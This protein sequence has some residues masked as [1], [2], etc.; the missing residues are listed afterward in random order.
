MNGEK[1]VRLCT[2]TLTVELYDGRQMPVEMNLLIATAGADP[3]EVVLVHSEAGESCS[4]WTGETK[5]F[6]TLALC[7]DSDDEDGWCIWR[8]DAAEDAALDPVRLK[9]R[10][11]THPYLEGEVSFGGV[12][13]LVE[14]RPNYKRFCPKCNPDPAACRLN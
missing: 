8:P 2:A 14:I 6:G 10:E 12:S 4:S 3:E 5:A 7:T 11:R 9:T 1:F 13:A